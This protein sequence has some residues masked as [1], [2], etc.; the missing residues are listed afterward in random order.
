MTSR[1][2]ADSDFAD[3]RDQMADECKTMLPAETCA[4]LER[5]FDAV[6]VLAKDAPAVAAAPA[7][8]PVAPPAAAPAAMPGKAAS[9]RR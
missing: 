2:R 3:Y 6:G 8:A 1:L 7:P 5:G 9:R 4:A